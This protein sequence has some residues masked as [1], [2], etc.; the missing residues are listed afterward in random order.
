MAT[1]PMRN[2]EIC[3]PSQHLSNRVIQKG[4]VLITEI[5]IG[6]EDFIAA[7]PAGNDPRLSHGGFLGEVLSFLNCCLLLALLAS[8]VAR[9]S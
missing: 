1:T 8:Y 6:C 4:D 5:R 2:P 7:H 9:G 3:M